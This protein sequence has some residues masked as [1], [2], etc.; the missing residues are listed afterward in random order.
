MIGTL[1]FGS[2]GLHVFIG[3]L[4]VGFVEVIFYFIFILFLVYC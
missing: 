3:C 2:F 1:G 4:V